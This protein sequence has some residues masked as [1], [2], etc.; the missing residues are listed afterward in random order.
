MRADV[1]EESLEEGEEGEPS[2]ARSGNG[3][4]TGT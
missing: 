2:P 4:G 1:L 3:D